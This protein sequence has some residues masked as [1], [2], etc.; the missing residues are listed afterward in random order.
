MSD[1]DELLEN[2]TKLSTLISTNESAARLQVLLTDFLVV[3]R[4]GKIARGNYANKGN[5]LGSQLAIN[6]SF[7]DADD[8][9][10]SVM[11]HPGSV[12][13][14]ALLESIILFPDFAY[15]F[16]LAASAGYRTSASAPPLSSLAQIDF[17]RE[18]GRREGWHFKEYN[19]MVEGTTDVRHLEI[20]SNCYKVENG[21]A[22]ID[23]QFGVLAIG[24][25]DE[26]GTYGMKEKLN[27]LWRMRKISA[28]DGKESS[29]HVIALLDD[30]PAGRDAF[31]HIQRRGARRGCNCRWRARRRRR[32]GRCG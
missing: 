12:I 29:C 31:E 13:W 8:I 21:L 19:L 27:T 23:E 5:Q 16:S 18:Y 25:A 22:L 20:A 14:A 17:F 30:D 24:E 4:A 2:L 3:T 1:G 28:Q 11:T 9:D 15:R 32:R 7:L 26:G 6:S 10:W